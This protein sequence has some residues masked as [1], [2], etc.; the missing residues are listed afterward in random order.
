MNT[1]GLIKEFERNISYQFEKIEI[2]YRARE[3]TNITYLN[4][5]LT[6]IQ[7]ID[8][9]NATLNQAYSDALL[10]SLSSLI[11]YYCILCM[12]KIGIPHYKIRKVQYRSINNKF[13]LDKFKPTSTNKKIQ[14][15]Q[16]LK[17]VYDSELSK[18]HALT[19]ISDRDYWIGFLGSAISSSLHEYGVS[20]KEFVLGYDV[21]EE[22]LDLSL[23]IK[24]YFS[25]MH[26]F[27]CNIYSSAGV[28]H[29]IYIDVNNFLKHNAVPYITPHIESFEGEK[30]IYSYFEIKNEHHLLLK[31]GILRDIVGTDF[32]ELKFNLD[33]R[34]R[35]RNSSGYLCDLEKTWDLGNILKLDP[36]NDHISKDNKTLYFFIDQVLIAKNNEAT[37]IDA[38]DSLLMVL[39]VLKREIDT[40][41]GYEYFD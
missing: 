30:R 14:S 22:R 38:G 36:I 26:P 1:P 35:N 23:D 17:G 24:K 5:T 13:I 9:H 12:L 34:H 28:K 39:R 41:M 37:L 29:S 21:Q 11:D 32:E 20:A 16:D 19:N 40:G 15:I 8:K 31:D 27:F 33:S 7:N 10:N 4:E 6:P 18:I 3:E 25:Y 2:L